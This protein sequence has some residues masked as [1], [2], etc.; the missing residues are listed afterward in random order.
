MAGLTRHSTRTAQK[1]A[2]E[3]CT[4]RVSGFGQRKFRFRSKNWMPDSRPSGISA[5]ET[6]PTVKVEHLS[7]SSNMESR[8]SIG[9]EFACLNDSSSAIPDR[10]LKKCSDQ[11][12]GKS[13]SGNFEC[14][15]SRQ[16]VKVRRTM[17]ET[18]IR[19]TFRDHRCTPELCRRLH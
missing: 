9:R 11:L 15:L 7:N 13:A 5:I 14:I 12:V 3:S 6:N 10:S 16:S 8:L 2:A 4:S 19:R 1:R 17:Y 18:D